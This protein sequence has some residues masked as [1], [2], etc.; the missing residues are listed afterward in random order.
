[1]DISIV[2]KKVKI[3]KPKVSSM[4]DK[5]IA[6]SIFYLISMISI[7]FIGNFSKNYQ[8]ELFK[9]ERI[10][11]EL[12]TEFYKV[13]TLEKEFLI[14]GNGEEAVIDRLSYTEELIN[15]FNNISDNEE[16]SFGINEVLER[17]VKYRENFN[18]IVAVDKDIKKFQLLEQA[19]FTRLLKTGINDEDLTIILNNKEK[20]ED[21]TLNF[22]NEVYNEYKATYNELLTL[23]LVF[24]G[25]LDQFKRQGA[26]I[27]IEV[28]KLRN[29]INEENLENEK[30]SKIIVISLISIIA[31][32]SLFLMF[33]IQKDIMK[34]V[35]KLQNVFRE[36]S[37]GHLVF[38]KKVHIS[39]ELG[40]IEK[41]LRIFIEK[42]RATIMKVQDMTRKVESENEK[43]IN[44]TEYLLFGQNNDSNEK[45]GLIALDSLIAEVVK[46]V[47]WQTEKT[48]ESLIF[49]N[50]MLTADNSTIGN[51]EKAKLS[52]KEVTLINKKNSQDLNN[53]KT[54]INQIESSV[55]TNK[56]I[57]DELINYSNNIDSI[58]K[59]INE[60][61]GRT[62]LLALNAAI[63]AA[64]AGEAGRGF[65][66]VAEEI[67]KLAKS[68]EK[69]T[70]KIRAI[71]ENIQGHI[72]H[73]DESN[74]EVLNNVHKSNEINESIGNE[75]EKINSILE[76]NYENIISIE[77]SVENQKN[78]TLEI[79]KLF[80]VVKENSL[81]VNFAGKETE[82]ISNLAVEKL[83]ET[84]EDIKTMKE[85]ATMVY[86]ELQF[87]KL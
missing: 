16:L 29:I 72:S 23:K 42:F 64:R 18:R 34:N 8:K 65:S 28:E 80:E 39:G 22:E 55:Y 58:V 86:D 56:Q 74:K 33:W 87:F 36:F 3:K 43:I 1:M 13:S 12:K 17:F 85:D 57:I 48:E 2:L 69:E 24:N 14:K 82:K 9:K 19:L 83:N 75:A 45:E 51:L 79:N 67:T 62:N 38:D 37:Q 41:E 4:R 78:G 31:L 50:D 68:S 59:A 61:S 71:V 81:K 15:R 63:E 21:L 44:S 54:S 76:E 11:N 70:E 52:S 27:E 49:L 32:V 6:L 66:V 77:R 84:L 73:V 46:S 53:L 7:Y 47:S 40:E 10:S 25:V 30:D 60:I 5:L 35:K 26:E 20:N